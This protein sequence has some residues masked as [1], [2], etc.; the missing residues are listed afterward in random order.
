MSWSWIESY[1]PLFLSGAGITI[2]LMLLSG[3][4]GFALAIAVAFMRISRNRFLAWASLSFTNL[5]RGTPLLVQIYLFYY[6][7]GTLLAHMPAIRDSLLWPYLREGF[8]YVVVALTCS[9]AAYV[10]EVIRGGLLAVPKGELEAAQAF[11][12]PRLT[13]IRRIWLP[14]AIRILLPT[15]AGESVMLLKSTA[16]ASTVAVMDL[17]GVATLVRVKTFIVYEPLL[18]AAVIYGAIAL[19]IELIFWR[20]ERRIPARAPFIA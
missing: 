10:G 13:M 14:R 4:T 2:S 19:L 16:L 8:W 17:L 20:L 15:L 9:V 7:L 11:A 1:A 6:G 12:I 18:L 3:L 5:I